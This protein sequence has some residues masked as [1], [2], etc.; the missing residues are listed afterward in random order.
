MLWD[1][2]KYGRE[3]D[4]DS[5]M[6]VAV[7][8]F[9][10]GAMENK[11]L[12][13]FNSK[14]VLADPQTATD[15]DYANIDRVVGHEYFHNWS[16]NRVTC[17]DWFQL[18]LKEGFTV[19]REQ[20]FVED[21]TGSPVSR[22]E[23]VKLLRSRQFAEDAGPMAHPIRPA[24]FVEINNFYTVTI[25]EKGSEV[26]RML[27]TLLGRDVFR[28]ACDEYF[29]RFDGMA[30]TTDDFVQVMQDVSGIDLE[31][32]RL[33]YSQSGT[34]ILCV[35]TDY[36]AKTQEYTINIK[37]QIPDTADMKN[38]K[39]MH[40][41]A[42]G[43]LDAKGNDLVGTKLFNIKNET[44]TIKISGVK[45]KPLPSLLR[46]FSAPVYVNYEYTEDELLQ[47]VES[48][49]DDFNKW[50]AGQRLYARAIAKISD[51][52]NQ[53]SEPGFK[54]VIEGIITDSD[55]HPSF[56]SQM[57][58]VPSIDELMNGQTEVNPKQLMQARR[59]FINYMVDGSANELHDLY[60]SIKAKLGRYQYD[61]ESS[62]LRCL[63]NTALALL[64]NSDLQ[65]LDIAK[66]NTLARTI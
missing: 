3:Y 22:I 55:M 39:P 23:Q 21:I 56:K 61:N 53:V 65:H 46:G 1:E 27:A 25:Y 14:Y 19:F 54:Q 12:N 66:T 34:P 37:Q 5:Y 60:M 64:V 24:S 59:A 47:L 11:G 6:I 26:I 58:Q 40:I 51:S 44:E 13:I 62:A 18:S 41:P 9:N 43:L 7:N 10:M 30:V 45:D 63:Q 38:K 36:N 48:D 33:W 28:K 16:G 50:D 35:D 52:E 57:L 20:S 15:K 2:Q 31:Q 8:D 29:N 32:F 4:L 42:Y 49:S 17:R